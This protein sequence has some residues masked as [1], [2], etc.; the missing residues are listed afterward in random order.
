VSVHVDFVCFS[1]LILAVANY[2]DEYVWVCVCLSARI[3]R[4]PHKRS[5]PNFLYM[6]LMAVAWSSFGVAAICYVLQILWMTS[7]FLT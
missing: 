7:C 5:L 3:S 1:F 4:N 2:C 6:L